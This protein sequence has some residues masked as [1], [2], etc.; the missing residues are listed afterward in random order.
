MR[1]PVAAQ[2][3]SMLADF[4]NGAD[5]K[6]GMV[7]VLHDGPV[8]PPQGGYDKSRRITMAFRSSPP[9]SR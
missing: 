6:A 5:F 2:R 7:L 1:I 9:A 8:L 3:A 4:D